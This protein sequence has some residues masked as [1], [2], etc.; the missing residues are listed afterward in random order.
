[1]I[2]CLC[3]ANCDF[4]TKLPFFAHDTEQPRTLTYKCPSPSLGTVITHNLS[5]IHWNF[6]TAC[7]IWAAG[8]IFDISASLRGVKTS[9]FLF[10]F[11]MRFHSSKSLVRTPTHDTNAK[12]H[13]IKEY[14][15][16]GQNESRSF[17]KRSLESLQQE[18]CA[19]KRPKSPV[20][21]EP[22]VPI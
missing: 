10:I 21:T 5:K 20:K 18:F 12:E 7:S 14:A 16:G 19:R 4:K 15:A 1:M 8:V 3:R 11:G 2:F 9:I 6:G 17:G 22:I 13:G